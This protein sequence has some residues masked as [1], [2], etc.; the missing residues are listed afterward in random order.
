MLGGDF[1]QLALD[2]FHRPVF[3]VQHGVFAGRRTGNDAFM[4]IAGEGFAE[5]LVEHDLL[6][7]GQRRGSFAERAGAEHGDIERRAAG[8]ARIDQN[9]ELVFRRK[10][11]VAIRHLGPCGRRQVLLAEQDPPIVSPIA[12]LGGHGEALD[13]DRGRAQRPRKPALL[14]REPGAGPCNARSSA[15]PIRRRS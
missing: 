3:A 15:A 14:R 2:L 10:G 11:L 8:F 13:A 5:L 6:G 12:L 4:R 9:R 7:F 1:D